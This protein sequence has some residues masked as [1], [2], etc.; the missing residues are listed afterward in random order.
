MSDL[1]F[2]N[3]VAIVTGAGNGLAP[4]G[5]AWRQGD[6]QRPRRHRDRRRQVE[7]G[8]GQG[9]RGDQGGRRRGGRELRLR[10]GR[11][12]DRPAGARYVE[13]HRHRREQR[14]HP[15]RYVV[16]EDEPGRL[17]SHLPGTRA[18]RVPRHE[19]RVGSHARGR[20]RPHHLH[21][22]RRRHLRQL[23]PGELRD[24]EARA[25]RLRADPRAREIGRAHV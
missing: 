4:A 24:G 1:R 15:A 22:E 3:R 10:R 2:E 9:R 8:G 19:G 18:R 12:E 5:G 11:R 20:L 13:A 7:R 6:R 14:R 16:P 17:G 21:G 25:P 23:R